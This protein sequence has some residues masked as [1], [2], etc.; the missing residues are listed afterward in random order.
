MKKRFSRMRERRF[1]KTGRQ[2]FPAAC[3]V[4]FFNEIG[5]FG[6]WVRSFSFS[7]EENKTRRP[8]RFQQTRG[9][10]CLYG[11]DEMVGPARVKKPSSRRISSDEKNYR[12]FRPGI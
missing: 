8:V 7:G 10:A 9:I 12:D 4:P 11:S 1:F 6:I 3:R 5:G 2:P